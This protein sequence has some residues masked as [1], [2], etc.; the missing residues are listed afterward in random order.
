MAEV[1]DAVIERIR[2]GWLAAGRPYVVGIAG[3]VAVGKSV[4]AAA[5]ADALAALPERPSVAVVGTDGFLFPNAEL[6]RRGLMARK[7]F[8]ESYDT[9]RLTGFLAAVRAGRPADA[10]LYSHERYDVVEGAAFPVE[11]VD[12]LLLEGVNALQDPVRPWVD[13]GIYLDADEASVRGWYRERR[14]RIWG[15][16]PAVQARGERAWRTINRPNWREHIAPTRAAAEIVL[17]KGPDHA[18]VRL[19]E[20]P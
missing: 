1:P 19:E 3:S 5:L 15:D 11:G 17:V 4:F 14:A 18:L 13:L 2:A 7:G 8:P 12:L 6:A 10:P 20:L 16:S 9:A